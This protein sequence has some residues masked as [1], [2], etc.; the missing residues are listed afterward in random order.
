MWQGINSITAYKGKPLLH[1]TKPAHQADTTEGSIMFTDAE[2]ARD[3]PDV[4]SHINP[5]KTTGPGWIP[6]LQRAAE[7]SVHQPV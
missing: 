7:S 1:I 6:K 3:E 2:P 5:N 4:L